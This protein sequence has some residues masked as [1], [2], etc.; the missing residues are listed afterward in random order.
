[1]LK[2]EQLDEMTCIAHKICIL[3]CEQNRKSQAA[4]D[5]FEYLNL[6]LGF[7]EEKTTPHQR[8]LTFFKIITNGQGRL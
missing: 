1:M 4:A 5:Q 8:Q 6:D 3:F 2:I 7:G